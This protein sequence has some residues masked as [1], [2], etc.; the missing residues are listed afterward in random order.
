[1]NRRAFIQGVCLSG[2]GIVAGTSIFNTLGIETLKGSPRPGVFHGN[3]EIPILLADTPE[4]QTVGGA[5][6][7]EIDEI[8]KN[9][10]VARTGEDTFI[11]VDIKCTHK[12]CDVKYEDVKGTPMF[13]C[14]CHDSKFDANGIPKS[15]PAKKPLGVYQTSFK[16][17]ELTVHIPLDDDSSGMS[18]DSTV[19]MM[20]DSTI[21]K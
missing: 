15:G 17:G 4:L 9:I 7:L 14:P 2:I 5:Y 21:K 12:G 10:L 8:D 13:I 16:N 19:K 1:M 6:H 18:K 20:K 3:R 11:A